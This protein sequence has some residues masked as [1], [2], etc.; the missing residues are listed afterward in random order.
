MLRKDGLQ[1]EV[2]PLGVRGLLA[3]LQAV[4]Y[5]SI[6]GLLKRSNGL[7]G[8]LFTVSGAAAC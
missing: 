6:I 8:G 7:W 4:E 1:G 5:T 2:L 3:R